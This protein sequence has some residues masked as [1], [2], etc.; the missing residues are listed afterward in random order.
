VAASPANRRRLLEEVSM[1]LLALSHNLHGPAPDAGDQ[2]RTA[3]EVLAV[4]DRIKWLA[5]I[6]GG[7]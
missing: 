1:R 5:D 3:N 4:V 2:Q 6:S 7:P